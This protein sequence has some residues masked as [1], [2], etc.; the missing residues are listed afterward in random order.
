[1]LERFIKGK[2]KVRGKVTL[3]KHGISFRYTLH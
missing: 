1:M 3:F 2:G